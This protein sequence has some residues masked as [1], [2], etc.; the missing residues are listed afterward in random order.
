MYFFKGITYGGRHTTWRT[1]Y[2]NGEGYAK[3]AKVIQKTAKVMQKTAKAVQK[4]QT[5]YKNAEHHTK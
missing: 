2:K 5:S 3:T 1:S 4:W